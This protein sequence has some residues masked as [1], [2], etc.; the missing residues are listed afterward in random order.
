MSRNFSIRLRSTCSDDLDFVLAAENHAENIPYIR[1]WQRRRH[2]DAIASDDEAHFIIETDASHAVGYA[3]LQDLTSPDGCLMLRR[4]V[5]TEK[6]QGYG[7]QA[8]QLLMQQA[9]EVHGAH[10]LWLDVKTDNHRAKTLYTQAGFVHEGCLRESMKNSTGYS[11]MDIMGLL[12]PE[13]LRQQPL[14]TS[15]S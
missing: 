4:L 2:E 9:F 8:L 15:P 3:I 10:R 7:K 11:S 12:H 13:Y 1:Q 6:G 14:K 5:I